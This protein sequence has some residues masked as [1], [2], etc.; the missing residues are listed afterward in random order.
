MSSRIQRWWREIN[1][2]SSGVSMS[3]LS[4]TERAEKTF[5]LAEQILRDWSLQNAEL[6]EAAKEML[7]HSVKA[8]DTKWVAILERIFEHKVIF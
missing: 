3:S 2:L 8:G 4:P 6:Y 1:E 7:R 5:R